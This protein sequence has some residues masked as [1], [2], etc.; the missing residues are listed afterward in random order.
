MTKEFEN[1][2]NILGQK[3]NE[4]EIQARNDQKA[5]DDETVRKQA[6]DRQ[7]Q[8][9][10]NQR[11]AENKRILENSGVVKLFEEIRDSG[12]V[13]NSEDPIYRTEEETIPIYKEGFFGCKKLLH[14]ERKKHQI[15]IADFAPATISWGEENRYISLSFNTGDKFCRLYALS[16][17]KV[18]TLIFDIEDGKKYSYR[19]NPNRNI[20]EEVSKNKKGGIEFGE[21]ANLGGFPQYKVIVPTEKE[22]DDISTYI[23]NK[24]LINPDSHPYISE[25]NPES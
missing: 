23:V 22:I 6:E 18:G 12:I 2:K 3:Q 9:E 10:S 8:I 19:P 24:L 7:K 15:K 20:F 21:G 17:G 16:N 1:F 4:L 14:Y 25:W 11:A 5:K 13:K